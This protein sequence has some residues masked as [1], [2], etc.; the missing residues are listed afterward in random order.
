MASEPPCGSRP[1][2]SS[3]ASIR[4]ASARSP[5]RIRSASAE[6]APSRSTVSGSRSRRIGRVRAEI[7]REL[8]QFLQ[9]QSPGCPPTPRQSAGQGP[10]R[11][12]SPTLPAKVD[13]Q[14][15][16][17]AALGHIAD[18]RQRRRMRFGQLEQGRRL[19]QRPG[20]G[21]HRAFAWPALRAVPRRPR[22]SRRR[23]ARPRSPACRR[24]AKL[25]QPRRPDVAGSDL[26]AWPSDHELL[27]V[28]KPFSKR[29][30]ERPR[31]RLVGAVEQ[32]E[33]DRR[34]GPVQRPGQAA[35]G[36]L[37]CPAW[38]GARTRPAARPSGRRPPGQP[39]LRGLLG[40]DGRIFGADDI[41]AGIGS[42][43]GVQH[44][45]PGLQIDQPIAR[46]QRAP[47]ARHRSCRREC[48]RRSDRRPAR[49][50]ADRTGWPPRR[51]A[52]RPAHC[53]PASRPA[54]GLARPGSVPSPLA[55]CARRSA[56]HTSAATRRPPRSKQQ[57]KGEQ[58]GSCDD[59][60]QPVGNHNHLARRSARQAATGSWAGPAPAPRHP[61]G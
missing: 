43:G 17:I 12:A 44:H 49:P 16:Q 18:V 45:F 36:R 57:G 21:D 9:S 25:R 26:T 2:S 4:P 52:G 31:S 61:R 30:G 27:G 1:S 8:G 55:T 3:S 40:R 28:A 5:S 51:P 10:A 29:I 58:R 22:Q 39:L 53:G 35:L 23:P 38:S 41:D 6:S 19:A 54:P 50:P 60:D 56:A 15:L 59:I 11:P 34:I 7:E 14:P 42:R 32:V 48:R 20:D 37:H 13:D 33:A 47:L 46:P 24:T